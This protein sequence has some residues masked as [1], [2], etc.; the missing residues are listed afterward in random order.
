MQCREAANTARRLH[1]MVHRPFSELSKA[2]NIPAYC[3]VV[4]LYLEYA[5]G[6]NYLNFRSWVQCKATRLVRCLHQP[7]SSHWNAD[8][9]EL[10]S[11]S[12]STLQR[13]NWP[14]PVYY[15]LRTPR[16][17]LRGHTLTILKRPSRFRRRSG[18][19]FLCVFIFK[20]QLVRQRFEIFPSPNP[21]L[22]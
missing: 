9:S 13:C 4:R 20:N 15:F 3:A 19:S 21:I 8:A 22:L 12:P 17:G 7:T 2:A 5:M 10:T 6:V 18:A 1:F 16:A 11:F 14:K